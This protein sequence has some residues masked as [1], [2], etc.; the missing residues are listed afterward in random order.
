MA[1][2]CLPSDHV[3][4][5]CRLSAIVQARIV[6]GLSATRKPS[7]ATT[8]PRSWHFVSGCARGIAEEKGLFQAV[9]GRWERGRIP[10]APPAAAAAA[11][12][13]S[14][15]DFEATGASGE[16]AGAAAEECGLI[17]APGSGFSSMRTRY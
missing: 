7:F 14:S 6:R 2:Q 11:L 5:D 16:E 10:G 17:V 15:L 3:F 12:R 13:G 9:L 8:W 4:C 1:A